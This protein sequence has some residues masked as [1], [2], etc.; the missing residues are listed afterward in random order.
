MPDR[1]NILVV[2]LLCFTKLMKSIQKD[3]CLY[4]TFVKVHAHK[5]YQEDNQRNFY[6]KFKSIMHTFAYRNIRRKMIFHMVGERMLTLFF[7]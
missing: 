6:I 4:I 5:S 3:N 1:I 2:Y 7:R